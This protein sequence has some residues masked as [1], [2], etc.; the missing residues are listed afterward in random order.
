MGGG[1]ERRRERERERVAWTGWDAEVEW[2]MGQGRFG[3]GG[4]TAAVRE[5]ESEWYSNS[6]LAVVVA[7][8]TTAKS[9]LLAGLLAGLFVQHWASRPVQ[10]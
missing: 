5:C 1:V 10:G 4:C 8:E 9:S 2:G 7:L 3:T 6:N